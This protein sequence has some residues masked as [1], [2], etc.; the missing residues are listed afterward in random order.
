MQERISPV[1]NRR[2]ALMTTCVALIMPMLNESANLPETLAS[3][4][5]QTIDKSRLRFLAVDGDS[6]DGSREI[7]TAWF[8][9]SGIEGEVIVNPRRRI[10][11]SLNIG[12]RRAGLDAFILRLDAHTIY[13]STYVEDVVR[14]FEAAP[15]DVGNVGGA[16]YPSPTRD[17]QQTVVGELLT[18]PL[19]LGR[20]GV[21][22]L[23]KPTPVQ[24]VYLGSWRPGL[25]FE[26]GG[27]DERW[28]ANEDSELE[29]RLRAAGWTLLMIPTE[30][31]YKVKRGI[32]GTIRQWGGYGFWRAQTSRRFPHELRPRHFIAAALLV[33]GFVLLLTPWRWLDAIAYTAYAVAVFALR[34]KRRSL[35]VALACAVTFPLFQ[36]AWTF[37]FLRGLLFKPPPFEPALVRDA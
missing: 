1:Q 6:N 32:L 34:D 25:L 14:A 23:T 4:G 16:Q 37:G 17:F 3:I 35:L 13:G 36:I 8:A 20:L 7:V 15:A 2:R 18:H 11:I 19:G 30:N 28:I 31:L 29:A 9:T 24:T 22:G 21:R 27:F 12:A 5:R 10:P 33:L 26:L